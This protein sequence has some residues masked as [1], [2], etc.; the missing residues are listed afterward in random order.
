MADMNPSEDTPVVDR[1]RRFGGVARLHGDRALDTLAA[2]HVAVVGLGGVGSWA[3]EALARCGIGALTLID[4]D[5]VAESN[6]NRQVHALDTTLGMAKIQAM[7]DRISVIHPHCRLTLI[8]DFLTPD[9][10]ATLLA[11]PFTA[12]LDCTDQA[13]AK[14]AMILFAKA[15]DVPVIVC[16]GAGGKIDPLALRATDITETLNDALLAKVRNQ[17]RKQHGFAR[18]STPGGKP[19]K[20]IPKMH[21]RALWVNEPVRLPAA[22]VEAA[23]SAESGTEG[24]EALQGLSCAGYGSIVTVTAAM[25]LAAAHEVLRLLFNSDAKPAQPQGSVMEVSPD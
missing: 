14:V 6:I 9:N 17:L 23:V 24:A 15:N 11:G 5:H 21:I 2:A 7:A 16:G 8:D 12:I 20:R 10:A 19:L 13:A 18:A 25:G 1:E 22:W 3:A 4:L